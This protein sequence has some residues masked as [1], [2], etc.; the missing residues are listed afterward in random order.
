MFIEL[1]EFIELMKFIEF[2]KFKEKEEN[3]QLSFNTSEYLINLF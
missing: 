2:K 3:E 1:D